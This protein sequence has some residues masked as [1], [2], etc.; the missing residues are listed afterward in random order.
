[1]AYELD[2][3]ETSIQSTPAELDVSRTAS[4]HHTSEDAS[5]LIAE[6]APVVEK[7]DIV[8]DAVSACEN[9]IQERLAMMEVISAKLEILAKIAEP[10][11]PRTI[12]ASVEE[13]NAGEHFYAYAEALSGTTEFGIE[14]GEDEEGSC[15]IDLTEDTAPGRRN[16]DRTNRGTPRATR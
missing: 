2:A 9:K 5:P 7:L 3:V 15:K 12:E 16:D 1:V 4:A 11:E 13:T 6:V 8:L 14:L 10:P